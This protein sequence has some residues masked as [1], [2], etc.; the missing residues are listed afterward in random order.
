MDMT[1]IG[2]APDGVCGV[3]ISVSDGS[4]VCHD[5]VSRA[6]VFEGALDGQAP[7][8]AAW[9]LSGIFDTSGVSDLE[10]SVVPRPNPQRTATCRSA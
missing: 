4:G 1:R 7:S 5:V 9:I 3:Y 6:H 2:F 10:T 8:M